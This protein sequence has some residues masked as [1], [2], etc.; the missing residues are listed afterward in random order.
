[1][2]G[3]KATSLSEQIANHLGEM[4]VRGELTPGAK[5]AEAELARQLD[6]STNSLREAYRLL[7][8]RHLIEIQPRRGARVTGVAEQQVRELY[9]FAF[10]MLSQVA[11]RAAETWREGELDELVQIIPALEA[12]Q[13]EGDM[14]GAH[15]TVFDFLPDML[16]FARNSYMARTITD[17]IPLLQRYSFIALQEETSELDVSVEI[18]KRLLANVVA[19]KAGEAAA[20]IREYGDNQCRIVLRAVERRSAA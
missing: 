13:R 1:M 10:L 5:L 11:A 8:S 12:H 9:D 19:R 2:N 15:Q 6:V 16:R 3:L 17:I 4:I 14:A 18:F 20:D 7:E